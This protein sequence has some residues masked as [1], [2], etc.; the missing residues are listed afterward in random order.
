MEE[1]RIDLILDECVMDSFVAESGKEYDCIMSR[2]FKFAPKL[3]KSFY[4]NDIHVYFNGKEY[5]SPF[6]LAKDVRK[7]SESKEGL[8][9]F[10]AFSK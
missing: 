5:T 9:C 6:T 3:F 1:K 7:A 2:G 8:E 10:K 4:L